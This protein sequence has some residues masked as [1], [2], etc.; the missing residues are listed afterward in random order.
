MGTDRRTPLYPLWHVSRHNGDRTG[1]KAHAR[2]GTGVAPVNV[3]MGLHCRSTGPHG[4]Q[5]WRGALTPKIMTTTPEAMQRHT[6]AEEERP[7]GLDP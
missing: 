3:T 6:S 4:D 1:R 2:Q 5:T 7:M